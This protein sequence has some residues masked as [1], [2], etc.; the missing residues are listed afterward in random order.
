M[1]N[2]KYIVTCDVCGKEEEYCID[3]TGLTY[4]KLK[5]SIRCDTWDIEEKQKEEIEI[6]ICNECIKKYFGELRE[7]ALMKVDNC[8]EQNK[9]LYK[10]V[11]SMELK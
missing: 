7:K 4:K 9:D 11:V 3:P 10:E 8:Y 2:Q 5:L 1:V 6:D